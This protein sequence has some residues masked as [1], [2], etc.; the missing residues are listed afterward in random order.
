MMASSTTMYDYFASCL[1]GAEQAVC[2]ELRDLGFQSVRLNR[3]GIPFRGTRADG[4]RACLESRTAQRILLL[5]KRFPAPDTEHLYEAVRAEDWAARLTPDQTFSVSAV[6]RGSQLTDNRFVALSAKDAV[7]DRLRS[8]FG[9]RPDVDREDADVQI[10]VYLAN[11]KCSLYLDLSGHSLHRRGYRTDA[12]E[13]PLQETLAAVCLRLSGWDRSTPLI[14]PMCGS[15]TLPIEAAQWASGTAPGLTASGF[16]FQRWADFNEAAEEE[17]RQLYGEL[18]SQR[19]GSS[20]RIQAADQDPGM[21]ERAKS[22]AR[23]AGVRLAFRERSI[24]D[25]QGTGQRVHVISNPPY[26]RRLEMEESFPADLARVIA[27]WHGWRVSLLAGS[28]MYRECIP[29]SL[30]TVYPLKNGDLECELLTY[31]IP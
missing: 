7:A 4:W 21:L 30:E 8:V 14:D 25:L 23:R 22:N 29:F 9:Q 31:E 5:L 2:D 18:R 11:D 3:G 15:G 10:V 16:G 13:A 17:L 28:P 12:G 27:S 20:P 6:T 1:P 24:L 19:R 26:G